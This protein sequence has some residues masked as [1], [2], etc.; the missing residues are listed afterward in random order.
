MKIELFFAK[1]AIALITIFAGFILAKLAGKLAKRIMAEAELNKILSTAGL[2]PL[3][4]LLAKSIEYI[5]YF[6]TILVVLQYYG[7]TKITI[8]IITAIAGIAIIFLLYI[9]IRDFF[10]NAITGIFLRRKLKK[11]IGKKVKIGEVTGI[12]EGFGLTNSRIK[13]DDYHTVPHS[14]TSKHGIK[15][16][17]AKDLNNR[18]TH[19]ISSRLT[20]LKI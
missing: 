6:A 18:N 5:I 10:P 11:N 20:I 7:L 8:G 9:R 17:I 1:I 4:E 15:I 3:S 19:T 13:N 2:K 12:L 14:Y 16:Q